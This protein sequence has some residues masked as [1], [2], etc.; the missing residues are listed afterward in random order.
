MNEATITTYPYRTPKKY[1]KKDL[2]GRARIMTLFYKDFKRFQNFYV[3]VLGWDMIELPV[4]AGG[5]EP[6]SDKPS[7]LIATGPSYETYEGVVP[8]HMNAI[9]HYAQEELPKPMIFME[10]HGGHP[11]ADTI[12][13]VIAHGGR[14]VG[15][16]PSDAEGW[17]TS[18]HIEDPSGNVLQLWRP[19]NSRTWD[20]PETG[21]DKE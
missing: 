4:P 5:Q 12:H 2:H 17:V 9:A 11:I 15:D 3:N 14:I 1:P 7:V 21:Y 19:G 18:A 16:E 10:V 6:G 8:G 13:D 20:E